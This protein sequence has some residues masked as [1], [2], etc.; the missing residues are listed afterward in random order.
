MCAKAAGNPI[1]VKV[2][3]HPTLHGIA[4]ST[5]RHTTSREPI[6]V[7]NYRSGKKDANQDAIVKALEK[8]GFVVFSVAGLAGLGF[9]IVVCERA[10]LN[11]GRIVDGSSAAIWA[12]WRV[13]EIKSPGCEDKLTASEKRA[14]AKAP[15]PVISSVE[16]ALKYF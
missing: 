7:S 3:T 8:L 9:D 16:D 2:L 6:M 15:I 14:Q 13:F 10:R 11:D 1:G 4:P 12:V 5:A